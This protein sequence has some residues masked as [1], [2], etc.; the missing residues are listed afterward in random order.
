MKKSLL[1]TVVRVA[2][3]RRGEFRPPLQAVQVSIRTI[4]HATSKAANVFMMVAALMLIAVIRFLCA[5]IHWTSMEL[6]DFA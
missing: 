6:R 3:I 5:R 1:G 2:S 4:G